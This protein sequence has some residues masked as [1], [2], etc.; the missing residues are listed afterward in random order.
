LKRIEGEKEG[1]KEKKKGWPNQAQGVW[2][3]GEEKRIRR[4]IRAQLGPWLPHSSP[5]STTWGWKR[6]KD[7]EKRE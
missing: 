6:E 7:E 3:R 2:R 4:K 5:Q 1:R